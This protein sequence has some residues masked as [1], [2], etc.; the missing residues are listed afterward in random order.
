MGL[1]GVG[2]EGSSGSEGGSSA[3]EEDRRR[4]WVWF[5][6]AKK[7]KEEGAGSSSDSRRR[8]NKK[9]K[10]GLSVGCWSANGNINGR[11]EEDRV[12]GMLVSVH[13]KAKT[14]WGLNQQVT[15]DGAFCVYL[16]FSFI[17]SVFFTLSIAP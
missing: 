15:I 10:S 3:N 14:L 12:K 6:F 7:T 17:R 1:G 11:R 8:P 2:N 13:A 4:S 5:S 9:K 16:F